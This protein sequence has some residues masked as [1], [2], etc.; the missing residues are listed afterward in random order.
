[1]G[2]NSSKRNRGPAAYAQQPS[3]TLANDFWVEY[4]SGRKLS[5]KRLFVGIDGTS[6]A[7]YYDIFSSNVYRMNLALAF[8]DKV[9]SPQ[10][11]FLPEWRGHCEL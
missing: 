2:R 4:T 11:V 6:N 3:P 7:A 9:G 10:N 1:V 5:M 8:K